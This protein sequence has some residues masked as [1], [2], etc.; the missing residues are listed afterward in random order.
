MLKIIELLSD[1][2]SALIFIGFTTL[3]LSGIPHSILNGKETTK[4]R[5]VSIK[6][7]KRVMMVSHWVVVA[8][9]IILG[10]SILIFIISTYLEITDF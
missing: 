9:G 7:L 10:Y 4:R 1:I 8:G 2:G 3:V 5:I 6:I